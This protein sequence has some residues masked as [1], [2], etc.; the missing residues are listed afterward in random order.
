MSQA[1][2]ENKHY[3]TSVDKKKE[4]DAIVKRK[5]RHREMAEEGEEEEEEKEVRA[6]SDHVGV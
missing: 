4:I 3:L 5:R 6:S 2:R 1:K